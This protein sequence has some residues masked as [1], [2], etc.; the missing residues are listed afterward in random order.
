MSVCPLV[1]FHLGFFCLS[2]VL[3]LCLHF[4]FTFFPLRLKRIN[5]LAWWS[6]P[7]PLVQNFTDSRTLLRDFV[8][9][10]SDPMLFPYVPRVTIL[11]FLTAADLRLCLFRSVIL[12]SAGMFC[13]EQ[14]H[15]PYC[16]E[17]ARGWQWIQSVKC[18]C[19]AWFNSAFSHLSFFY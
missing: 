2:G 15:E 17:W 19:G 9:V 10:R 8:S 1:F 4:T 6:D 14:Q 18:D 3:P 11:C 7:D 12:L 16:A 13:E 5:S